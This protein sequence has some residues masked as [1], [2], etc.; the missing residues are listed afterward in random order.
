M[1]FLTPEFSMQCQ[2]QLNWCWAAVSS[3]VKQ[4]QPP[5]PA[6]QQCDTAAQMLPGGLNCCAA[7][8]TCN[9]EFSLRTALTTLGKLRQFFDGQV[10]FEVI[11]Q[12]IDHFNRPVCARIE[13]DVDQDGRV[14]DAHFIVI[15][16]CLE[17]GPTGVP[18]VFIKDP[19]GGPAGLAGPVE[20]NLH[21]MAFEE[22][23]R[24]YRLIGSW[25]QTYL[26]R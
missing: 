17:H 4:Y 21:D 18:W 14:D 2:R 13:W 1:G 10:T 25:Q 19:D 5:L 7:P 9:R 23:Q 22:F 24:Q 15:V 8:N 20:S 3:A 12:Q 26:V 6:I 11:K 16:G